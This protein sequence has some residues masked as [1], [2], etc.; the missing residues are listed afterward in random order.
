MLL[1]I[2]HIPVKVFADIPLCCKMQPHE[3]I[4]LAQRRFKA[5]LEDVIKFNSLMQETQFALV[6]SKSGFCTTNV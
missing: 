3:V 4:R 6:I 5:L 2:Y 1:L